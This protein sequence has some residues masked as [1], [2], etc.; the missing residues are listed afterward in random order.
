MIS[1]EAIKLDEEE[2]RTYYARLQAAS[3]RAGEAVKTHDTWKRRLM[4]G[5]GIREA[6]CR[7]RILWALR[8]LLNSNF[9]L[10]DYIDTGVP[11]EDCE[12]ARRELEEKGFAELLDLE[13]ADWKYAL[14][15]QQLRSPK[16]RRVLTDEAKVAFYIDE[17]HERLS[18]DDIE[19][20]FWFDTF[21]RLA[22]QEI[23]RLKADGNLDNTTDKNQNLSPEQRAVNDFVGKIIRLANTVHGNWHGKRMVPAAHQPEVLIEIRRDDLVAYLRAKAKNDF[24]GLTEWCYPEDSK[25]KAQL[26]KYVTRL[27]AKG[28]FGKLPSKLLAEALAPIVKLKVG[29]VINYLSS[30]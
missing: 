10:S 26:C 21:T 7:Q 6:N 25:S 29:T 11:S 22:Y 9:L 3:F 27:Q 19:A 16:E 1:E 8:D 24:D 13:G 23:D 17:M 14:L 2:Y 18:D 15:S 30:R 5:S 12:Y 20:F 28:Y 4:M